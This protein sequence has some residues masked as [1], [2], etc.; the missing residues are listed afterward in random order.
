LNCT[1][2]QEDHHHESSITSASSPKP[3]HLLLE[4]A[5]DLERVPGR[6]RRA[7]RLDPA[8]QR[9]QHLEGSVPSRGNAE[10]VMVRNWFRRC[11]FSVA[12]P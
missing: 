11:S 1:P 7:V 10:T 8:E 12:R 2:G 9:R 4:L 6:Q 5:A 3:F